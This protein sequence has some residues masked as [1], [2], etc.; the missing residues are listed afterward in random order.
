MLFCF[1]LSLASLLLDVLTLRLLLVIN[2]NKELKKKI[3]DNFS[4]CC[5]V[6]YLR[7]C[8][9]IVENTNIID[10]FSYSY[11]DLSGPN[12]VLFVIDV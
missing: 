2:A 10:D 4:P 1:V 12:I 6:N 7:F 11:R 9:I 8:C 3:L 5:V